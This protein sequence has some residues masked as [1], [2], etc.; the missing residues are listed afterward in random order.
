MVPG[1]HLPLGV[2][3]L[4][5]PQLLDEP[6]Q[7]GPV[8]VAVLVQLYPGNR[9]LLPQFLDGQGLQRGAEGRVG[10]RLMKD[11]ALGDRADI[12]PGAPH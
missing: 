4:P 10:G 2:G 11:V 1:G 12:E 6:H 7:P 8:V 9:E 3:I 5:I